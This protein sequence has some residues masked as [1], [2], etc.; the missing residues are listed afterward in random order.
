M[1]FFLEEA[2]GLGPAKA[3]LTLLFFPLG[4]AVASQIG[5]RLT[6]R[7]GHRMPAAAGSLLALAGVILFAPFDSGWSTVQV[8]GRLVLMGVGFGLFLSPSAVAAM[9]AAPK[10]LVGVGGALLNTARF[11]GFALGPALATVFWTPGNATLRSMRTLALVL[12]GIETFAIASVLAF[13]DKPAEEEATAEARH[14]AA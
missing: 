14:N 10:D 13:G 3:G 1:P 4:I 11:L 9:G 6:D 7:F 5:G 2:Q 12:A 8:A